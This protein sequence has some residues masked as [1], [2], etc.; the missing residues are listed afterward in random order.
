MMYFIISLVESLKY[1]P[2]LTNKRREGI[3]ND[4]F[5]IEYESSNPKH[6][7]PV[8]PPRRPGRSEL[9]RTGI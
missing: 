1:T 2:T 8:L 3:W 9:Y 7:R 5:R 4:D 6:C